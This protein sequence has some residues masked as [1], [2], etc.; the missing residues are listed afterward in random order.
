M[1]KKI[2]KL[3]NCNGSFNEKLI[4]S[5]TNYARETIGITE[6]LWVFINNSIMFESIDHSGMYDKENFLK[7]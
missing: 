3:H 2:L 4:I 1:S 7:I 5:A 6:S